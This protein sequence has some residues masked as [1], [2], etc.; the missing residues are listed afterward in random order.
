MIVGRMTL[1]MGWITGVLGLCMYVSGW[2]IIYV[3]C[4][5]ESLF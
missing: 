3:C 1:V 5:I 2:L 4:R